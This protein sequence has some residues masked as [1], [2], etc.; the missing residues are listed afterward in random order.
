MQS[1]M[2]KTT[3]VITI[4]SIRSFLPIR[5]NILSNYKKQVISKCSNLFL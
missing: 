3:Y 5:L 4:S 2:P 1:K